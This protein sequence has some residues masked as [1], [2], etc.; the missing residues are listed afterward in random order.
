MPLCYTY[1]V[2]RYNSEDLWWSIAYFR[3]W[4]YLS[5]YPP[6]P[7]LPK[8]KLPIVCPI[9]NSPPSPKWNY[10]YFAQFE[11]FPISKVTFL[12]WLMY[13]P[14]Q[15]WKLDFRSRWHFGYGRC[16]PPPEMKSWKSGEKF[17]WQILHDQSLTYPPP[18][19]WK[20]GNLVKIFYGRFRM[21]KVWHTPPH[22]WKGGN[23]AK[24]FYG[25]FCM[26]KVWCT[27][28]EMFGAD[29]SRFHWDIRVFVSFDHS[30]AL[31]RLISTGSEKW[32]LFWRFGADWLRFHWDI[33]VFVT[34][35]HSIALLGLILTSLEKQAL[36]RR[37][38]ADR[39][40][41]FNFLSV[42]IIAYH[43]LDSFRLAQKNEPC[44]EGSVQMSWDSAEIFKFLLKFNQNC[45]FWANPSH[46]GGKIGHCGSFWAGL[47]WKIQ[48]NWK[49]Q[50]NC[51]CTPPPEQ[52]FLRFLQK[53]DTLVAKDGKSCESGEIGHSESICA[54]FWRERW[55]KHAKTKMSCFE[56]I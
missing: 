25:R 10:Q 40:D 22:K 7:S 14:P 6:P 28:L 43:S 37:L 39:S 36:F 5:M 50:K 42:L 1:L 32:A 9:W 20:V 30:I 11:T 51:Q 34:F 45:P 8:M 12:F 24:N 19:K 49:T 54:S 31:L 52:K 48:K 33:R 2:F 4:V 35:D 29:Q 15:E 23:L 16:T 26:T 56:P 47:V 41:I 53:W 38:G 18:D 17:L 27:P 46:F 21:T 44:S 3:K 13:P 55:K